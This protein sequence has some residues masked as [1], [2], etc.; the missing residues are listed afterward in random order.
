MDSIYFTPQQ[1]FLPADKTAQVLASPYGIIASENSN[2]FILKPQHVF[3][4]VVIIF[5]VLYLVT[6]I[7]EEKKK[8]EKKKKFDVE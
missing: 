5:G 1:R 7:N 3:T 8:L 6:V 4:T 2:R